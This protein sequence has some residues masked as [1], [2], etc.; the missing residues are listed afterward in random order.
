MYVHIFILLTKYKDH[1]KTDQDFLNMCK[2]LYFEW[3]QK[4][5]FTNINLIKDTW[6]KYEYYFLG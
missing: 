6:S 2:S 3:N 1:S 4:T 5:L